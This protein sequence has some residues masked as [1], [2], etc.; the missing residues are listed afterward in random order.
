MQEKLQEVVG[1]LQRESKGSKIALSTVVTRIEKH[2]PLIE[3]R[4]SDKST[5]W[6]NPAIKRM[7]KTWD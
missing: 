6:L 5:P 4:V 7:F 3:R 1:I 2:A